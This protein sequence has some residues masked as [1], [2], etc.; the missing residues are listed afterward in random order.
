MKRL[1]KPETAVLKTMAQSRIN[2]SK[3]LEIRAN[4][5]SFSID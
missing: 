2:E 3:V 5:K 1:Q 4:R